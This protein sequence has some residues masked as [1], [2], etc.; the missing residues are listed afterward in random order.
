VAAYYQ[1]KLE[2]LADIFGASS[3]VL[4]EQ[5]LQVAESVYPIVDDVIVVLDPAHY[6][7][8]LRQ[9]LLN[10]QGRQAPPSERFSEATQRSFGAEWDAFPEVL[11][12]HETEFFQ[13]FD[14]IELDSLHEARVADLGCGGGRWSHFLASFARELVLVDFSEAIFVA[15]RNLRDC[16]RAIFVMGDVTRLPF[17]RDFAD[18]AVCLGVL[19]HLPIPALDAVRLLAAYAPRVLVYLY[20]ALDNRPAHYRV[21][22]RAVSAVRMLTS[23]VSSPRARASLCWAATAGLYVPLV[24]AGSMLRRLGM[25]GLVPLHD[26]YAG[27]SFRRMRQDVYDRFFASI[28]QRFTRRQIQDLEDTFAEVRV[29]PGLP[30]WHFVCLRAGALPALRGSQLSRGIAVPAGRPEESNVE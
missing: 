3:V 17:R 15:R 27:K 1:D 20:Y 4:K 16:P 22:L 13:Y 6:P 28:E 21:L 19:H 30:F 2:S 12:E 10:Y 26:T 29:S 8:R 9:R 18:L 23:R 5:C 7:G 25:G 11:R 14:L 24:A